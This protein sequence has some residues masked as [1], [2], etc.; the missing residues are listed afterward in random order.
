[1][2]KA[3]FDLAFPFFLMFQPTKLRM[4]LVILHYKAE[5]FSNFWIFRLRQSL[6]Q[7]LT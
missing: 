3:H 4:V 5:R 2:S 7:H 6:V 1:M